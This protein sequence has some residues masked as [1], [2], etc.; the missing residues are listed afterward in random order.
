TALMRE[1]QRSAEVQVAALRAADSSARNAED[2][3][4]QLRLNADSVPVLISYIDR[5]G[6]YRFANRQYQSWFGMSREQMAGRH[7]SEMLG[8]PA[9]ELV[10][11]RLE[12]ALAGERVFFEQELPCAGGPREVA[13]HYVPD[14]DAYGQVRGCFA[15]I[16]DV[17][18]RKR[19]ERILRETDRR[20]DE[21]LAILAHELRN[22]LTP[23]RNVAYILGKGSPDAATVR[24]S[25]EMLERQANQ[26]TRLVADL[27]DVGRIIR[28]RVTLER[29]P[30]DLGRV[31]DTALE[32]VLPQ[33]DARGQTVTVRRQELSLYVA[34]DEVRLCQ[35]VS[36]LLTNASKYSP[37]GARIEV[38]LDEMEG[39]ARLAVRDEGIGIDPEM[40][41]RL[42]D[43][44]LQGDRSL[45]R[46]QDGLGIG[47]TVVRHVIELHGGKV[48]AKS[49]GLGKGS[50]FSIRVARIAAP[51]ESLAPDNGEAPRP[52]PRRRV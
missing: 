25:G 26:L 35:V 18:P 11:P 7:V 34:G 6:V 13:V 24:R 47:L 3:A 14:F 48:G 19:A 9:F 15:L 40:L 8:S 38:T 46:S 31:L 21:F 10:R 20:K 17:G 36:N 1:L 16:E 42:F 22:P 49:P 39:D 27:L 43:Q 51:P 33:L 2:S 28:G 5:D 12:R 44:F 30:L 45:D 52:P 23:I 32:A 4:A 41:P 37:E 29:R 50:E